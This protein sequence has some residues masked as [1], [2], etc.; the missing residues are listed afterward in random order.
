LNPLWTKDYALTVTPIVLFPK[1]SLRLPLS[2]G[3][4][5]GCQ[6]SLIRTGIQ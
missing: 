5:T 1:I 2:A 4:F 3:N 6:I